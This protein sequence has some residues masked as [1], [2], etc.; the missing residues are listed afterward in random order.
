M[1]DRVLVWGHGLSGYRLWPWNLSHPC[2]RS[3]GQSTQPILL[4]IAPRSFCAGRG[5]HGGEH[6]AT[7]LMVP[8]TRNLGFEE[9]NPI[10][11][12]HFGNVSYTGAVNDG[13]CIFHDESA[14]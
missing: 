4:R 5:E 7:V 10:P 14:G 6:H 11:A 3:C 1:H 8:G 2:P 12:S 9:I 13:T